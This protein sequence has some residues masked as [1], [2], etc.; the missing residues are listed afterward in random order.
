M[1]LPLSIAS[2]VF[3]GC[4]A[5]VTVEHLMTTETILSQSSFQEIQS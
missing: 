1:I 3:T 4:A 2:A 5:V